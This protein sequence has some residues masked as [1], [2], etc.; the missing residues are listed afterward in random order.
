MIPAEIQWRNPLLDACPASAAPF[1]GASARLP[2]SPHAG[3]DTVFAE[4]ISCPKPQAVAA[5][6]AP[7]QGQQSVGGDHPP[8]TG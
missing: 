2:C 7:G 8:H 4:P 6:S 1:A 5:Q 3:L